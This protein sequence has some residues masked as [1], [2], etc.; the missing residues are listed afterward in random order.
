M[1]ITRS[2]SDTI[3][4]L[5]GDSLVGSCWRAA[6]QAMKP[7][8][9]VRIHVR[10]LAEG[11]LAFDMTTSIIG[12]RGLLPAHKHPIDIDAARKLAREHDALV[13]IELVNGSLLVFKEA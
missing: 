11:L 12:A 4:Y 10:S 3:G 6:E 5:L 2:D 8:V 1:D 7:D 13:A 9:E